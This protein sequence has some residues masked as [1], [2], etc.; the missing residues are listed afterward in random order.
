[1]HQL[2]LAPLCCDRESHLPLYVQIATAL[3]EAIHAEQ[4][5][6]GSK[7]PS[8]AQLSEHFGVA[9]MTVRQAIGELRNAG[10]VTPRQGRGAIVRE[11]AAAGVQQRANQVGVPVRIVSPAANERG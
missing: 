9:R 6:A 7:L 8:E 5:S 3:R 10:L 2:Q 11:P 4:F 1:M